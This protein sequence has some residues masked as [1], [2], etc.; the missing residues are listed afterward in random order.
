MERLCRADVHDPP[1]SRIDHFV[2]D[3]LRQTHWP[4]DI[5]AQGEFE[6]VGRGVG[7]HT[8]R[9]EHARSVHEHRRDGK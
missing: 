4:N 6:I 2:S 3:E 8:D 5:D 9:A 7:G 1:L